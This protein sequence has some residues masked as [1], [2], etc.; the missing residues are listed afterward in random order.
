MLISNGDVRNQRD[1]SRTEKGELCRHFADIKGLKAR[2]N[3]RSLSG[4][5]VERT[6]CLLDVWCSVANLQARIRSGNGA[7]RTLTG[8]T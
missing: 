7:A 6:G 3:V 4:D 5:Q 8:F 2:T 1:R